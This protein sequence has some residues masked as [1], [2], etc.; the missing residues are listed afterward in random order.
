[1]RGRALLRLSLA[2]LSLF[3]PPVWLTYVRGMDGIGYQGTNSA[4]RGDRLV[5]PLPPPLV[6][7][8]AIEQGI[9]KR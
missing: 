5:P 1:M 3:P 9:L 7:L 2:S 6:P 4:T 8:T